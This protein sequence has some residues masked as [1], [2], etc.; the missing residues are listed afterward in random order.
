VAPTGEVYDTVVES[1]F[2]FHVMLVTDRVDPEED[3]LPTEAAIVD[4]LTATAVAAELQT[5]FVSAMTAADVTV[6]ETYGIWQTT[7][8]PG[9][10]PPTG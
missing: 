9:V 10:V 7:P 4:N 3:A 8:E 5:W 6:D 1:Q 2:G